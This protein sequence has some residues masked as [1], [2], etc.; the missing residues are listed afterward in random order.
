MA[1]PASHSKTS[2]M[3]SLPTRRRGGTFYWLVYISG[4][5]FPSVR[6]ILAGTVGYPKSSWRLTA[7]NQ[8]SE[9]FAESVKVCRPYRMF[10]RGRKS[11]STPG[12]VASTGPG[13]AGLSRALLNYIQGSSL[14][15]VVSRAKTELGLCMITAKAATAWL[16]VTQATKPFVLMANMFTLYQA[17]EC[18]HSPEPHVTVKPNSTSCGACA[19]SREGSNLCTVADTLNLLHN[20]RKIGLLPSLLSE[21][22]V[23]S[24]RESRPVLELRS[25]DV[26]DR[27]RLP[28]SSSSQQVSCRSTCRFHQTALYLSQQ[29]QRFE[30]ASPSKETPASWIT[31]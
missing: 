1:T 19:F 16:T 18:F 2:P 27:L 26:N 10:G 12:Q 15:A 4:I 13:A 6:R 30:E 21:P 28:T 25:Q 8:K 31:R 3:Q 22:A 20:S 5:F 9:Y 7:S 24:S 11:S 29:E 17:S 23:R 14:D